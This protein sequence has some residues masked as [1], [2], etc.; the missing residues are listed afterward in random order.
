MSSERAWTEEEDHVL[1]SKYATH[2]PAKLSK[3]LGRPPAD[4]IEQ[5]ANLGVELGEI[6]G[7]VSI[8]SIATATGLSETSVRERALKSGFAKRTYRN[9]IVVPETW[10]DAY[11][12]SVTRGEAADEL[13]KHH[14]DLEKVA[15]IFRLSARTIRSW[16]TGRSQRGARIMNH[17]TIKVSSGKNRRKYLFDPYDVER[18]AKK[19]HDRDT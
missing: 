13:L 16:V 1:R 14:Y 5:A 19:Y 9:K 4:V 8:R 6:R 17:I 2:G 10:A 3:M 12:T 7:H 15:R 11:V 18:E